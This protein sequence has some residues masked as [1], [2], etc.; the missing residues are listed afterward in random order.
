MCGNNGR[1]HHQERV[2]SSWRAAAEKKSDR[3]RLKLEASLAC[4]ICERLDPA[5]IHK[6]AA[7][8]D[9]LL[10]AELLALLCNRLADSSSSHLRR[11]RLVATPQNAA[12]R[13]AGRAAAGACLVLRARHGLP[14]KRAL[15]CGRHSAEP[16]Q[17]DALN[18]VDDLRCRVWES[19]FFM[20][21]I[22]FH[23]RRG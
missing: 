9:N 1:S 3:T 19:Y 12:A 17:R 20:A 10:N 6:T 13:H 14:L 7:V 15:N 5:V 23:T 22:N 11:W 4:R 8:E 16:A 2:K 21:S 18:V